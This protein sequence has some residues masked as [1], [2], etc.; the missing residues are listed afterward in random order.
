MV[1]YLGKVLPGSEE[2]IKAISERTGE[3]IVMHGAEAVRR[4]NLSTQVPMQPIYYTTGISRRMRVG[5]I[6]ITF[7]HISP[8]KLVNPGTITCKSFLHYGIQG[9]SSKLLYNQR[10]KKTTKTNG[11]SQN[12]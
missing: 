4:L 11:N 7:K 2:I 3:I 12:Y 1:P 6:E 8:S 9:K 5:N 10:N